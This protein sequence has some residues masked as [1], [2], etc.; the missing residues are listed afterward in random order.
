MRISG[1]RSSDSWMPSREQK[2]CFFFDHV[3]MS[4][5]TMIELGLWA[6]SS[7][8]VRYRILRVETF[9]ELIP[10]VK[11]ILR[12]KGMILDK[13][14]DL[15][16]DKKDED[17]GLEVAWSRDFRKAGQKAPT[18]QRL[19]MRP[20]KKRLPQTWPRRF[21]IQLSLRYNSSLF[22]RNDSLTRK[23]GFFHLR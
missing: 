17:I 7:K 11:A 5:G 19:R 13:N 14:G 6:H 1:P 21:T 9:V 2:I 4:P 23:I 20:D 15:R 8:V 10:L 16:T 22:V 12:Q 3:T 18:V